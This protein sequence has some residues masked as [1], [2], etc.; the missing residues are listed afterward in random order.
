MTNE[1]VN[2]ISLA[3]IIQDS[4][5]KLTRLCEVA[6]RM[7]IV[8]SL[9]KT[10]NFE[11]WNIELWIRSVSVEGVW[12]VVRSTSLVAIYL[13]VTIS[14]T[15]SKS[16]PVRTIDR[17]LVVVYTKSVFGCQG[18]RRVFLVTFYPQMV[19]Y[20]G[21]REKERRRLARFQRSG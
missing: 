4:S 10:S 17:N 18:R 3:F 16:R 6:V 21:P 13:H 15:V 2:Q 8:I 19:Q 5:V 14:V 12:L 11:C 7:S 20:Q 1:V 9:N